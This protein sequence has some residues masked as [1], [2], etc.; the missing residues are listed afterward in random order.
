M[1]KSN[2]TLRL[3]PSPK[4]EAARLA[5]REGVSLNQWIVAAVMEKIAAAQA[6]SEMSKVRN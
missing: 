6:D 1:N 3:P 5:K 4:A 2:F